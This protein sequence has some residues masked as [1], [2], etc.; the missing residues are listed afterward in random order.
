MKN[1]NTFLYVLLYIFICL[2][3]VRYIVAL[4]FSMV[5]LSATSIVYNTAIA[6]FTIVALI[7]MMEVKKWGLFLF[8][9]LQ[10]ANAFIIPLFQEGEY[11]YNLGTSLALSLSSMIIMS[12]LLLFRKDGM[13]AWKAFFVH[14]YDDKT[15]ISPLDATAKGAKGAKAF[16]FKHRYDEMDADL[17]QLPYSE[18]VKKVAER[19]PMDR[20]NFLYKK[21]EEAKEAFLKIMGVESIALDSAIIFNKLNLSDSI[22]TMDYRDEILNLTYN[23]LND[24][25]VQKLDS[26]EYEYFWIA[27]FICEYMGKI[28]SPLS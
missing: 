8:F 25:G 1:I 5:S 3:I 20:I 16:W 17:Y 6:A 2:V 26:K 24:M 22:R 12:L 11:V 4:T 19:T 28:Y 14:K 23:S 21:S 10:I 9:G 13:C 15:A 27:V 18:F 7:G